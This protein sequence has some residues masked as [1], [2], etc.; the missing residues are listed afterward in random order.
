MHA[1]GSNPLFISRTDPDEVVKIAIPHRTPQRSKHPVDVI[2]G[3]VDEERLAVRAA[4][5]HRRRAAALA[6]RR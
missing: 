4:D 3:A 1:A 5:G 2:I 6:R